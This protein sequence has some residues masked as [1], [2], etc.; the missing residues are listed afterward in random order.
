MHI[1][2]GHNFPETLAYRDRQAREF[3][4]RLIV[5][6]VQ[7]TINADHATEETGCNAL[8][9]TTLLEAIAELR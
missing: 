7:D 8:Q 9:T 5:R 2:T 6:A 1:D 4:Y 3:G